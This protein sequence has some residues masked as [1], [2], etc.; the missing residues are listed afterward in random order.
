MKP[1]ELGKKGEDVAKKYLEG[2]RY[3]DQ[4]VRFPRGEIDLVF[5]DSSKELVFVEV[6]TRSV[7]T[8]QPPESTLGPRK[9]RSLLHAARCYVNR[10]DWSGYWRIDLVAFTV[11]PKG[12]WQ[13]AHFEDI[14]GGMLS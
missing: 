5:F 10:K 4:N 11:T 13:V 6:R 1:Q 3:V 7:G 12:E 14:A 9:L 8:L 2:W